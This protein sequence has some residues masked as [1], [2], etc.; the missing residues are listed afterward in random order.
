[1]SK[2]AIVGEG[3]LDQITSWVL[4]ARVDLVHL[5][6]CYFFVPLFVVCLLESLFEHV[7]GLKHHNP[8]QISVPGIL[9]V[10]STAWSSRHSELL[11]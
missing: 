4:V 9:A 8:A 1:M 7:F 2:L 6:R 3:F 10:I 11:Q 5:T